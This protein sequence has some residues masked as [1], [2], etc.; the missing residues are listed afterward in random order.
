[1]S[2]TIKDDKTGEYTVIQANKD[3]SIDEYGNLSKAILDDLREF[4][5]EELLNLEESIKNAR[6]PT[7][8]SFWH[9]SAVSVLCVNKGAVAMSLLHS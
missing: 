4:K 7:E 9:S 3:R 6:L 1:L 2:E 5:Q 8:D